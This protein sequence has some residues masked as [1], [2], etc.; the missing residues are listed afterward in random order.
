MNCSLNSVK[1]AKGGY[2]IGEYDRGLCMGDTRSYKSSYLPFSKS[3]PFITCVYIYTEIY[4]YI[5]VDIYI[6]T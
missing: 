6:Y 1:G 5:D 2:G 3:T 4:I